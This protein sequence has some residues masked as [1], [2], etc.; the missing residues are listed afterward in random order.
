MADSGVTTR[1]WDCC[2]PSCAWNDKA[3]VS[4]PVRTCNKQDQW[5]SPRDPNR[6]SACNGGDAF[7]CSNNSPW[8]VNDQLAYGFA[9]AK[10]VG[11]GEKE[12]CCACYEL[13]FTSTS[14][15]GKKMIVQVTNTGGDLNNNQF[16]L[17]IPGGGVGGFP[18]GCAA[19]FN[20]AYMGNAYGGY[21]SRDQC[22]IL[23]A[24]QFCSACFF[25]FDWFQNADNPAVHFREVSC[26]RAM[27]DRTG[28]GKWN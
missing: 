25:R 5:F 8:A 23:P 18:Q 12:W 4:E 11:K 10:L 28:C 7:T 19:Q 20:S 3:Q 13:T 24:G 17:A 14:I 6:Q 1:Y 27:I 21:T 9:A 15:R 26:P 22:N 2:K 16:D